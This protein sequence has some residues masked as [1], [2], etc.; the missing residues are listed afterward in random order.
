MPSPNYC[1]EAALTP[2]PATA[3]PTAEG[4]RPTFAPVKP[5]SEAFF[6]RSRATGGNTVR[7]TQVE[8]QRIEKINLSTNDEQNDV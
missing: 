7:L 1:H 3:A 2:L 4:A 6:L 8:L 5:P